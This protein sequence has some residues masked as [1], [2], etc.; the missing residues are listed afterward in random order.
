MSLAALQTQMAEMEMGAGMRKVPEMPSAKSSPLTWL[1]N[2][3]RSSE[4]TSTRMLKFETPTFAQALADR[5]A[6]LRGLDGVLSNHARQS[7]KR[8]QEEHRATRQASR[9][10]RQLAADQAR[11][12]YGLST[13][14]KQERKDRA[15]KLEVQAFE[16]SQATAGTD[17]VRRARFVFVANFIALMSQLIFVFEVRLGSHGAQHCARRPTRGCAC[18]QV[19]QSDETGR[20]P[21]P[22]V[23]FIYTMCGVFG[24]L[25]AQLS[26]TILSAVLVSEGLKARSLHVVCPFIVYLQY[27]SALLQLLSF[28]NHLNYMP[29]IFSRIGHSWAGRQSGYR[30]ILGAELV[31]SPLLPPLMLF[32]ISQTK[33]MCYINLKK[34]V[35][36]ELIQKHIF[37]AIAMCQILSSVTV[38]IVC[39]VNLSTTISQ[40]SGVSHIQ[41]SGNRPGV[42]GFPL[43]AEALVINCAR[44]YPPPTLAS[45]VRGARREAGR[46]LLRHCHDPNAAVTAAAPRHAP[47]ITEFWLQCSWSDR[48]AARFPG[49]SV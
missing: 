10:E 11:L 3:E 42:Y 33:L 47:R 36:A 4:S 31:L 25:I 5:S 2:A 6:G 35:S 13:K 30:A 23:V 29:E 18:S 15:L 7:R 12:E 43:G 28:F 32:T 34:F 9:L 27:L 40:L 22:G 44:Q 26:V 16:A 8:E 20:R 48:S 14:E 41:A 17:Y 1:G 45:A 49:L 19:Y 38:A 46:L 37:R 24:S 39:G 21:A